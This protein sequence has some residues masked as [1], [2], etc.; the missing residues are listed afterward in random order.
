MSY[1][2]IYGATKDGEVVFV[3]E[4]RNAWRGAMHVWDKLSE[5][6]GVSGGLF[7]GFNQLWKMA[8]TGKLLDFENVV[9]KSTFDDVIVKKE[10]IPSLLE[11][12]KEYDKHFPDSS[13]LEQAE[14]IEKEILSDDEMLAVCWNQTSVNSNPWTEGYD[15]ETEEDIPYNIL[16]GERH[17]SLFKT[18]KEEG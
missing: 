12:F 14:I 15:E 7:S 18:E 4:T 3:N 8:D 16:T 9:M 10:N 6:Y 11:A 17:W 2:E 1:T 5:K 13:L